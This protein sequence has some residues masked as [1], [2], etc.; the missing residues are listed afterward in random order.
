MPQFVNLPPL[1]EALAAYEQA[2]VNGIPGWTNTGANDPLYYAAVYLIQR[3]HELEDFVNALGASVTLG[4]ATG[5]DLDALLLWPREPA[6]A[7]DAEALAAQRERLG[8]V[9]GF[10][11]ARLRALAQQTPGQI[12]G[13]VGQ[14]IRGQ[15]Y[16]VELPVQAAGN[17]D[18]TAALL[19]AVQTY[20]NTGIAET[21]FA[22]FI[23]TAPTRYNYSVYGT[24]IY[25]EAVVTDLIQFRK[26]LVA[27]LRAEFVELQAVNG[28]VYDSNLYARIFARVNGIRDWK[29][30][31]LTFDRTAHARAN[32]YGYVATDGIVVINGG[33][34]YTPANPPTITVADPPKEQATVEWTLTN[35][36]ITGY[37]IVNPG[38]GYIANDRNVPIVQPLNGTAPAITMQVYNGSVFGFTISNGG[39]GYTTP[40]T[41]TLPTPDAATAT[42][43]AVVTG[44]S[45]TGVSIAPANVGSG[46]AWGE[47]VP[48]R[49][50][51]LDGHT[52]TP[53]TLSVA[54]LKGKVW[55]YT[56]INPGSGYVTAPTVTVAA[57]ASGTRAT[58][59]SLIGD[60]DGEVTHLPI[61]NAGVG[62]EDIPA[63][64][65]A[66]PAG[67]Q[68]T[69]YAVIGARIA[70]VRVDNPGSD[71]KPLTTTVTISA[72][73]QGRHAHAVARI[74]NGEVVAIEITDPG[75]GYT[76]VPT[77]T[78]TDTDTGTGA[79]AT[80][81]LDGTQGS[82]IGVVMTDHGFG[83]STYPTLALTNGATATI[84]M[85]R[86]TVKA[87]TV[88]NPGSG[89]N[90]P[91]TLTFVGGRH[92]TGDLQTQEALCYPGTI[93]PTG[94]ILRNASGSITLNIPDMT[95]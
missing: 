90:A 20:M 80:A 25:D 2:F 40:P 94:W 7:T 44:D 64:T 37:T 5:A 87:V 51:Q 89:F 81:I 30:L 6:T 27:A 50:E 85:E 34:G 48:V 26:D 83:Y 75:D 95:L 53:A 22:D 45:V 18:P 62:Y 29:D 28:Y 32:L 3:G 24:V 66:S 15:D 36:V 35:G 8:I 46:Y 49:V 76:Q 88:Q 70:S 16:N 17:T 19:T 78:I 9:S 12:V 55:G 58:A 11:N 60:R 33:D 56:V 1:V 21:W 69:G 79:T 4:L 38:R 39:T 54:S 74:V 52:G 68:A 82:L 57:P 10:S 67:R 65:I 71:Y 41:D 86:G 59:T 13:D 14:P 43:T 42:A 72:S 63:V 61:A 93:R 91:P 31:N 84:E 77:I 23:A 47:P 92:H 73:N